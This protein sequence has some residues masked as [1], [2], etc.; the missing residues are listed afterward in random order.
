M[1]NSHA[2][3]KLSGLVL[4]IQMD[5]QWFIIALERIRR[6][7]ARKRNRREGK[8]VKEDAR[9]LTSFVERILFQ[10]TV[11]CVCVCV[12]VPVSR[13]LFLAGLCVQSVEMHKNKS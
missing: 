10:T 13:H 1:A 4:T 7:P 6:C 12:C 3:H 2:S 11:L 8:E 9:L 5:F